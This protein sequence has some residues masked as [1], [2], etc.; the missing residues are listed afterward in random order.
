MCCLAVCPPPS[1]PQTP[2]D[3]ALSTLGPGCASCTAAP[4]SSHALAQRHADVLWGRSP[5]R[6]GSRLGPPQSAMGTA[7]SWMH[8]AGPWSMESGG[9]GG[10]VSACSGGCRAQ[11]D[12]Q[13]QQLGAAGWGLGDRAT[14][15][16]VHAQRALQEGHG[17][18]GQPRVAATQQD[19]PFAQAFL[20][21]SRALAAHWV[22]S[23][24]PARE[25]GRGLRLRG[26]LRSSSWIPH[27]P[28]QPPASHPRHR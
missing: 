22:L 12:G 26:G 6:A 9:G 3:Q 23:A 24:Q 28:P 18:P 25:R 13:D 27:Q 8:T 7:G 4:A 17:S 16:G 14:L 20:H 5:R 1:R 2:Q 19:E 11:G 15:P 21:V 10:G